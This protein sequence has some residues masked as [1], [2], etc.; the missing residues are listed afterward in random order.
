MINNS[1]LRL[2]VTEAL[3]AQEKE[4]NNEIKALTAQLLKIK[5]SQEFDKLNSECQTLRATNKQQ[6]EEITLLKAHSAK[7]EVKGKLKK[8]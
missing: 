4:H 1:C 6:A 2:S 8:K 5:N 7:L 3:K